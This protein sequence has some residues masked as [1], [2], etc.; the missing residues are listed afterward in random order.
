MKLCAVRSEAGDPDVAI[1]DDRGEMVGQSLR[2]PRQ[3]EALD[4]VTVVSVDVA[5]CQRDAWSEQRAER[6]PFVV[7]EADDEVAELVEH[8]LGRVG[9]ASVGEISAH[10]RS[11]A[12][13]GRD[14]GSR[15]TMLQT[16]EG[17]VVTS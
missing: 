6:R 13:F 2:L 1:T 11:P 5:V 7:I 9:L 17:P 10:R 15:C 14:R 8:S 4:V 12:S 16:S 3:R